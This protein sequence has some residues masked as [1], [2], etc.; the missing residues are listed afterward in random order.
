MTTYRPI[1]STYR[2]HEIV[3]TPGIDDDRNQHVQKSKTSSKTALC[4]RLRFLELYDVC[5]VS[6]GSISAD[7]SGQRAGRWASDFDR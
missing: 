2:S 3:R 4:A 7:A 1:G 6:S 5:N